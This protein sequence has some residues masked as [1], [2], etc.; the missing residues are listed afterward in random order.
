M[1]IH[2]SGKNEIIAKS[3]IEVVCNGVNNNDRDIYNL[4]CCTGSL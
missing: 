3:K 2:G 1:E 4:I